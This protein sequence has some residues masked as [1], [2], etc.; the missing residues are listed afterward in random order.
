LRRSLLG[1]VLTLVSGTALGAD[2][3]EV[4]RVA[5][6]VTDSERR[7]AALDRD[8]S[9]RRGLLGAE[10]AVERYGEAVYDYLAGDYEA[11]AM[12]FYTLVNSE[13]LTD[14]SL[15]YDCDYY[16]GS[17]LQEMGNYHTAMSAYDDIMSAGRSHPFFADA[18]RSQLEILGLLDDTEGFR[19][20]YKKYILSGQIPATDAVKYSVAKS[21][22]HQAKMDKAKS[23]FSELGQDSAFYERARYFTGSILAAEGDFEAAI[24]EFRRVI[25]GDP[26]PYDEVVQLSYLAL[27]RLYYE[28][29]EYTL[30]TDH[31]Q[32][33]PSESNYFADQLYELV[34]TYIKQEM[35]DDALRHIEIFLIAFPEHRYTLQMRLTQGHLHMKDGAYERA[36]G[37]YSSV[38]REYTPLYKRLGDL[39]SGR[40]DTTTFFSRIVDEVDVFRRDLYTLPPYAVEMMIED[41]QM[42]RAVVISRELRDEGDDFKQTRMM[43]D[44]VRSVLGT[45]SPSIG[46]F[47]AGRASLTRLRDDS[48]SAKRVLISSELQSLIDSSPKDQKAEL[49]SVALK[50]DTLA[51]RVELLQGVENERSDRYQIHDDQVQEVQDL[52]GQVHEVVTDFLA[53]LVAVRRIVE[54]R[55]GTLAPSELTKLRDNLNELEAQ[56]QDA[57]DKLEWISSDATRRQVMSN[58]VR[59]RNE[60][61]ARERTLIANDYDALHASLRPYRS[62]LLEGDNAG[63]F[64]TIDELWERATTVDTR[65]VQVASLMDS[66]EG[67]EVALL[68]ER[69][70]QEIATIAALGTRLE[71][72]TARATDLSAQ[73]TV[74]AFAGLRREIH[75][76]IM[77]ADMGTVDVYW[78]RKTEVSDEMERLR[79]ARSDRVQE[80]E[81]RFSLIRSKVE[82]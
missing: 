30:A 58:V 15:D 48:L 14:Q 70:G 6:Q 3:S 18:V 33:I 23:M 54:D 52:A 19:K 51:E 72:T 35:W 25:D 27:G 47:G 71:D 74:A 5:K 8:F 11:A 42:G 12:S 82:E 61:T 53:E 56:C 57:A 44:E 64:S 45:E 43:L 36:L 80:L 68:R 1:L 75:D 65:A 17:S 34:W 26:D 2:T 7:M 28:I 21:F 62:R 55:G 46:T 4:S 31:Y 32:A 38:T 79:A 9:Q 37:T 67:R 24:A 20:L 40:E 13:A 29:E 63:V 16:L 76:T 66:A 73:V 59:V 22:Y 39:E 78:I 69:L 50:I 60:D 77:E 10:Q 41:P 49:A 81:A